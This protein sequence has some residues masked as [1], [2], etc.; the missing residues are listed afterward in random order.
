MRRPASEF[1]ILCMNILTTLQGD[2]VVI[3]G[4]GG[5]L[6]HLAIQIGGKGMGFRMIVSAA[7]T[8]CLSSS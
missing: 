3:P 1:C 8:Q 5:G 2:T 6:G 7:P 4:A